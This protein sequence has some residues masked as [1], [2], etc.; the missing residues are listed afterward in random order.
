MSEAEKQEGQKTVVAF[1]AGLLI[2]GLLVWVFSSSPEQAPTNNVPEGDQET[3]V[4]DDVVGS[5]DSN[6]PSEITDEVEDTGTSNGGA[7]QIG[8]GSL[9]VANQA[10]GTV[11]AIDSVT[12]PSQNGWIVVRDYA[13][14]VSGSILGASRFDTEVGLTPDTVR[15]L[16][17]TEAGNTYQ[18]MFY[19]E[20]GDRV[21]DLT[22]DLPIS[23]GESLFTAQ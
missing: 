10:A 8:D 9:V 2:G 3:E 14:G 18:V 16:R 23:G 7:I 13:D 19:T 12:Y 22:D 15:V 21:F 1:I 11:V 5:A 17:A 4:S 20:N 6:V